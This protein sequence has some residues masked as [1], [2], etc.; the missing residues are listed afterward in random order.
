MKLPFWRNRNRPLK[1]AFLEQFSKGLSQGMSVPE[2][3]SRLFEWA[4]NNDRI[5]STRDGSSYISAGA[6]NSSVMIHIPTQDPWWLGSE[7]AD[8]NERLKVFAR[9]GGDGSSA[10]FWLDNE[11]KQH[12]VHLGSGSGSVMIGIWVESPLDFLRLISIGYDEL[13]WPEDYSL[14]PEELI[15]AGAVSEAPK[16]LKKWVEQEFNTSVPR[17]AD[18]LVAKMPE[19][20][21]P[22]DDPFCKWVGSLNPP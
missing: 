15:D 7:N 16:A 13:C 2:E 3:F 8:Y 21:K 19:I 20:G 14:P 4:E 1:N 10:A 5:R 18:E 12:I 9:T 22:S 6:A 11:G 17:T